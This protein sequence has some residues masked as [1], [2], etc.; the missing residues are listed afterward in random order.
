MRKDFGFFRLSRAGRRRG[1]GAEGRPE[2]V[3]CREAAVC[4]QR[5]GCGRVAA[6]RTGGGAP[7]SRRRRRKPRFPV[8]P[9]CGAEFRLHALRPGCRHR[10]YDV[11][12][13]RAVL[14]PDSC[15][16]VPVRNGAGGRSRLCRRSGSP[17]RGVRRFFRP[18]FHPL[19]AFRRR[20]GPRY[21]EKLLSLPEFLN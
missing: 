7:A 9:H 14:R 15:P 18:E 2:R 1:C 5:Y 16:V 6:R 20:C 12:N 10:A 19:P 4:R 13:T 21:A 11:G 3:S 17:P 8:L